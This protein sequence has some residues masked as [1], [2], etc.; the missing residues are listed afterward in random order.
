MKWRTSEVARRVD[1]EILRITTKPYF[2]RFTQAVCVQGA[3]M[4]SYTLVVCVQGVYM[5]SY[6]WVVCVQGA[7]M[8][9][10]TW[11]VY[12][13]GVYMLSYMRYGSALGCV[14]IGKSMEN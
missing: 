12:V 8:L 9:S 10:Y 6:M 4:L 11:V 1:G 7:Y 5:M 13:Q 14:H 2:M 3:Y